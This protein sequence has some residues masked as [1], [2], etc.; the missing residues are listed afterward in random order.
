MLIYC[1]KHIHHV[2]KNCS[3]EASGWKY[4]FTLPSRGCPLCGIEFSVLVMAYTKT[5]KQTTMLVF[6]DDMDIQEYENSPPLS[7]AKKRRR[8]GLYY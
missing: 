1:R 6:N 4:C 7:R 3:K 8:R 5:V 2:C